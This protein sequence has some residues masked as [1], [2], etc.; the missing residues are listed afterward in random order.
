[1]NFDILVGNELGFGRVPSIQF[2]PNVDQHF[3][4]AAV[5]FTFAFDGPNALEDSTTLYSHIQQNPVAVAQN[6]GLQSISAAPFTAAPS[7]SR[8]EIGAGGIAG[9]CIGSVALVAFGIIVVKLTAR[10]KS[11]RSV[12]LMQASMVNAEG[13]SVRGYQDVEAPSSEMDKLVA[14]RSRVPS[15]GPVYSSL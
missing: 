12:S 11:Q 15:T 4:T 1:V 10:H 3:A 14:A 9:L 13:F 7:Q 5:T 2:N 8:K 6:L